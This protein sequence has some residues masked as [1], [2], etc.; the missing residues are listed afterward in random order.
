MFKDK[1]Y[2]CNLCRK[3][4][5]YAPVEAGKTMPCP[6]C[7]TIV[8]LPAAP[9]KPG[10]HVKPKSSTFGWIIFAI[11]FLI[12]V[13]GGVY[14]FIWFRQNSDNEQSNQTSPFVNLGQPRIYEISEPAK[15]RGVDMSVTVSGMSF[16]CPKVYQ[17]D[18]KRVA[19]T[20]TPVCCVK[21]ILANT[22][23][24]SVNVKPWR[25]SDAFDDTKR[26]SLKR[27]DGIQYSLVSFGFES[28]PVGVKKTAELAPGAT[29]TEVLFFFSNA[30][31][32]Q[33]LE[34]TL[35]CEN[36]GGKGDL[37]FRIP[38]EEIADVKE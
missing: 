35:P 33:G 4:I 18:L 15:V 37:R 3:V 5:T 24:H 26:A 11:L 36:L 13:A 6:F 22:G 21:L 8:T 27:S 10:L 9:I 12:A 23:K 30:R 14:A 1:A 7:K 28:D 2:V 38:A 19:A 20:E 17:A 25:M 34:L 29:Q 16:G 32:T 31:P